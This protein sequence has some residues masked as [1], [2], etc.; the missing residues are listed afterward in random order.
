MLGLFPPEG[1]MY[2]EDFLSLEQER[3][4][5]ERLAGL[6]FQHFPF[7][8][9]LGKRRVVS[10]GWRYDFGK[11]ALE[12]ADPLPLFL[13]WLR[14]SAAAF[15]GL[16]SSEFVQSSIVEYTPGAAIGWH[17]DKHVFG[18]VVGVS[19]GAPCQLRF[20]RL[21]N[22]G[23]RGERP[24]RPAWE[25]FS[26]MLAPRSVYLLKGPARA[27]WQHS[28]PAASNLRY[29]ITFRTMAARTRGAED[30]PLDGRRPRP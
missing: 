12:P 4:L 19:L 25:R 18:D 7:R 9:F 20:R 1:F 27:E 23:M 14:E 11:A 5:L 30:R 16:T 29:S 22:G 3:D 13:L 28:I 21:A 24:G 10:F 26:L 15:A 2:R 17:R 6:P 8:G